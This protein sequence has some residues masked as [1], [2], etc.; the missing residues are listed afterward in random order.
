MSVV[1]SGALS[2]IHCGCSQYRRGGKIG[3][4]GG[5]GVGMTVGIMWL[6]KN[7]A[8]TH[9]GSLDLVIERVGVRYK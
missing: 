2:W 9:A 5:A 3:L 8:K 7:I 1:V 6:T 4:F